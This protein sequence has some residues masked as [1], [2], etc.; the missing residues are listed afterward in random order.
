MTDPFAILTLIVCVPFLGM[1]F[2]LTSKEDSLSRTH[3]GSN[4]AVFTI[5]ANLVLIWRVFMLI[6]ADKPHL[7]LFEKFNWLPVPDINLVF[8][9]D[10]L[11]LL[12]IL[13][14]HL[15]ILTGIIFSRSEPARQKSTMVFTLLFLSMST[16]LFVAADIFSF[17]IFFEAVL[18]PLFMLIGLSGGLKKTERTDGFLLYNLIGA[19]VLFVGI[20]LIYKAYGSLTLDKAPKI[21]WKKHHG[22]WIF[23]TLAFGFISRIP[24]WPFHYWIASISSKIKNPLVFV[25]SAV[26]PLSGIYG[27]IRFWPRYI[28]LEVSQYFVWVNV[29]GTVTMLFIGLIGLSNKESQYKIFAYVTVGYIMY[30]LGIFSQNKQIVANI[31]YALFGFLII[32]GALESLSAYIRS[33]SDSQD[34]TDEGFLCRAK[35]LSLVY[36]FIT[37]AAI[38]F[39]VSAVFTNNFLILSTLLAGNI[40]MGM[41]LIVSF[42]IVAGSLIE[43][44]FRLKTES[45]DCALGKS[46]DLPAGEFVF[47]L[48]IMF[49]LLMSFI[50]PLWFVVGR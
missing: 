30:L 18:L 20:L 3:N 34:T 4:V 25:A 16:G 50:R 23:G 11:S 15:V 5:I 38:G 29:I 35:R 48:F 28:P 43:E 6:D 47:M 46:D 12:M 1:L 45:K 36:S 49:V 44:M 24:V 39:P 2:V 32:A 33:K 14:V 17:F 19:L 40:Q 26:L 37:V 41:V 42:L 27:L 8:A 21:L 22:Y 10:N 9:V 31:G 7:Q 13:A